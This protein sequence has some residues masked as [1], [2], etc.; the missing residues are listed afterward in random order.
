MKYT[1]VI[2]ALLG[3]ISYNQVQAV[4]ALKSKRMH[5][6]PAVD[7]PALD[8]PAVVAPADAS[9]KVKGKDDSESDSSDSGDSSDSSKSS[10]SSKSSDSED[11]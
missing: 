7:T 9:T 6:D 8:T 2:A 5:G 3:F 10:K 11:S 1:L 4:D